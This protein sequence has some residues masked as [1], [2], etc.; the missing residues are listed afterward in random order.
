M[1]LQYELFDFPRQST[2]KTMDTREAV[3][4][5]DRFINQIPSRIIILSTYVSGSSGYESWESTSINQRLLDLG[6]WFC[7]HVETV[8]R[9]KKEKE[10]IYSNSPSWFRAIEIPDS[11]LSAKT[12]SLSSDIGIYLASLLRDYL[13]NINWVMVTKPKKSIDYHQ[14]VLIGSGKIPFNPIH[15]V[16]TYAYGIIDSSR[17]AKGL[18]ELFQIWKEIL[19]ES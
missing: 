4:Y 1:K 17:D 15:L 12:F 10:L 14:P 2:L 18:L 19:S 7:E 8:K 3:K 16:T 11:E 6:K 9:S 5:F 13:P